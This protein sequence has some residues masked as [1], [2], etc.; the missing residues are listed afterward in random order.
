MKY[1]IRVLPSNKII[2]AEQDDLLLSVLVKNNYIIS[3][4]CGG[5]GTCGKCTVGL[6][7]DQSAESI[8][9]VKAC[10]TRVDKDMTII[11]NEQNGKGVDFFVT[12]NIVGEQDG[13]GVALDI[14]TTT[15]AVCL[16]NMKTGEIL[17]KSSCLNPQSVFGADVLSRIRACQDGNLQVLQKL[18]LDKT[19]ELMCEI[20]NGITLKELVV[21]A[22]TTMLHLFLWLGYA[23]RVPEVL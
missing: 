18:I 9:Y 3:A 4:P 20:A 11:V 10:K 7:T 23:G 16:V 5:Q 22:N 19:S 6:I 17:C 8:T 1:K 2:L 21:A 12:Q 14:G 15:I 13:F